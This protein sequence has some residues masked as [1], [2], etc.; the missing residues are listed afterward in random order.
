MPISASSY[1]LKRFRDS[2]DPDFAA[3]LL[4]YVRNTPSPIRT[5]TNEIAYWLDHFEKTLA[6][7]FYAFG[8]Y[9]DNNLVGFAEAAYFA[10]E[11]LF[12]LDYLVIDV[13][14]RRNNV[15]FE[16]VDHLKQYC[17]NLHPEYRYAVVEV[18]Y[19][20]GQTYPSQEAR[21][22]ARL[23]KMQGFRIARAPYFQPRMKL[24]DAE[25]EMR[26][27]LLIYSSANL[28]RIR[29]ETYLAIVRTIYY[30]YYAPWQAIVPEPPGDY[31]KH[32]DGLYSEIE[33]ELGKR[34]T[35]ILNG[36]KT[37]LSEAQT[38]PAI[39]LHRVTSFSIQG[40]LVIVLLTAGMLGLKVMFRLSNASFTA[41]YALAVI[42]FFAVA[43]IVSKSAHTVFLELLSVGKHFLSK[44]TRSSF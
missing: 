39:A 7:D 2:R 12:V 18:C 15:F 20:P 14:S 13:G 6:N 10:Q 34:Q 42:S 19:G 44:R 17:E 41:I 29:T 11:C 30:A 9:R 1:R 3:A 32:L 21:L 31:K 35:V 37:L 8:F 28:E 23:L 38:R 25:S 27:D 22:L 24:A 5:D 40:L 43:A 16:F 36:H 33:S 26:A 4:L